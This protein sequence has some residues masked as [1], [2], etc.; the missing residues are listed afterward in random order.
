MFSDTGVWT[1]ETSPTRR[2]LAASGTLTDQGYRFQT[3]ADEPLLDHLGDSRH[4]V[5]LSR[6]APNQY[7]WDTEVDFAIGQITA[8]DIAS[9]LG[10]FLAAGKDRPD[11]EVRAASLA[12][13][14]RT[15]AVLEHAFSVDT[16]KTTPGPQGTTTVRLVIGIHTE[17]LRVVYPHLAAYVDK[18]VNSMHCRFTLT[19]RTGDMVFDLRGQNHVLTARF[20][21]LQ[22]HLV[23][24]TGVPRPIGDSLRL[25][26][27]LTVKLKLFQLGYENLVT[28]F[29]I[30]TG[31]HER[32]WTMTAHAEPQWKLPLGTEHLI[33]TPLKRPFEGD[34]SMFEF[35][36]HDTAG[37]QTILSRRMRLE[38][39]ENAIYRSLGGFISRAFDELDEQVE[40]EEAQF[41]REAFVA[42]QRDVAAAHPAREPGSPPRDRH[43]E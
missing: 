10:T 22:D 17:R 40:R 39:Q 26:S 12:A 43:G 33:R 41:L 31:E 30:G 13:Y 38:L 24:Y 8:A 27:D 16:F 36:V 1:E 3:S 35:A 37:G 15:A 28:D 19:D 4:L 5:A 20:R 25:S 7:R 42:V 2:L 9:L 18:Y 11:G 32:S 14:P 34:G 23:A 29:I 21:V 6:I